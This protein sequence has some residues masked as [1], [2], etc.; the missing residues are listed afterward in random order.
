MR[1]LDRRIAEIGFQVVSARLSNSTPGSD[2]VHEAS[3]A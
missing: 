2:L 1:E 3:P